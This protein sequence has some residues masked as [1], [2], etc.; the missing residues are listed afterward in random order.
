VLILQEAGG[1]FTDLQGKPSSIYKKQVLM[2]N[3]LIHDKMIEIL[4][5]GLD[6]KSPYIQVLTPPFS[7]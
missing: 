5:P 6:G 3:G 1:R 4:K 2:T 7:T